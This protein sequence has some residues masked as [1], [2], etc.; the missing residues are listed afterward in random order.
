M[1]IKVGINGFGRIGR[2]VFK[3]MMAMGGFEIVAI[4]DITDSKTLAHLLKY[5]SVHGKYPGEVKATEGGISVNGKEIKVLTENDPANLPWG[6]LG[7]EFSQ[8]AKSLSF[9]SKQE[10]RKLFYPLPRKMTSIQ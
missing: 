1:S 6:K 2:L 8:N 5:D 3:R 10:Q 7:A 9:I 4:N